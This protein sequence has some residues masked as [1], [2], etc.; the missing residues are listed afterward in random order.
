MKFTKTKWQILYLDQVILVICSHSGS[1]AGI[2]LVSFL[3]LQ[4]CCWPVGWL[5]AVTSDTPH[6]QGLVWGSGPWDHLGHSLSGTLGWVL[7]CQ[8]CYPPAPH[9]AWSSQALLSPNTFLEGV[10]TLICTNIYNLLLFHVSKRLT[11]SFSSH[12]NSSLRL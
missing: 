9:P 10:C 3:Q 6:H 2:E 5:C 4:T 1:S 8:L 11:F 12:D 7:P